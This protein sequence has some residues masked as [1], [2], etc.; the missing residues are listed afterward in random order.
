MGWN[1]DDMR[2]KVFAA[3]YREWLKTAPPREKDADGD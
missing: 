2:D 3:K 1:P